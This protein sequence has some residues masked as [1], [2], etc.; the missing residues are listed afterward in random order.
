MSES[1]SEKARQGG[2]QGAPAKATH[3]QPK[4]PR[5]P[6]DPAGAKPEDAGLDAVEEAGLESYPA[7]DPPS[8][9]P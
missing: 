3:A 4:G 6:G 8:W 1:G 9:N 2:T 5:G 7:S